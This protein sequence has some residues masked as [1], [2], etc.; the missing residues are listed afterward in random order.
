MVEKTTKNLICNKDITVNFKWGLWGTEVDAISRFLKGK[1]CEITEAEICEMLQGV[2]DSVIAHGMKDPS[3]ARE[4][5]LIQ[6][7]KQG[8]SKD[9]I[10]SYLRGWDSLDK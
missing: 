7:K 5:M 4:A 1:T 10:K 6:L 8:K 9:Y 3:H 2:F